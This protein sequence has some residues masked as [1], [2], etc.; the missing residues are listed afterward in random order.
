MRFPS[1]K[2]P[3]FEPMRMAKGTRCPYALDSNTIPFHASASKAPIWTSEKSG[4]TCAARDNGRSR[5]RKIARCSHR[6]PR[7]RSRCSYRR[8]PVPSWVIAHVIPRERPVDL[9]ASFI[10]R[11]ACSDEVTFF[12]TF[13]GGGRLWFNGTANDNEPA[14]RGGLLGRNSLPDKWILRDF[15]L[16]ASFWHAEW[17][18]PLAVTLGTPAW[19]GYSRSGSEHYRDGYIATAC[20]RVSSESVGLAYYAL[21]TL[22][23]IRLGAQFTGAAL[24]AGS[25]A[26]SAMWGASGVWS[27]RRWPAAQC[28]YRAYGLPAMLAGLF[29]LPALAIAVSAE[30]WR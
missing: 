1:R 7:R 17:F 8:S 9:L 24:V 3:V 22:S 29:A 10:C 23:L 26:F 13:R 14:I 4:A 11:S 5:A 30:R 25:A 15:C 6:A 27:V 20:C 19:N 2:V 21:Y 16:P 28:S 18:R 12:R